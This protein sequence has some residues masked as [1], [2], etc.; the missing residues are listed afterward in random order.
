MDQRN[1]NISSRIIFSI[2]IGKYIEI[3]LVE[4]HCGQIFRAV[5]LFHIFGGI[6]SLELVFGAS[7]S[8]CPLSS[9]QG[10]KF[11]ILHQTLLFP[12]PPRNIKILKR[13]NSEGN[14]QIR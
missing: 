4:P 8:Y 11:G 10:Y 12:P 1:S 13:Q 3:S 14:I 7:P 6:L 2:L 9:A 5:L